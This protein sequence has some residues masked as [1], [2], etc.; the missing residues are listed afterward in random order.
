MRFH[1][2]KVTKKRLRGAGE[3]VLFGYL[4]CVITIAI[5]QRTT[6]WPTVADLASSPALI[7]QGQWWRI[8]TSG[9]VIQGPAVPQIIAIAVLGSLSIYIGGSWVFWRTAVAGHVVATLVAYGGFSAIWL[10]DHAVSTRFLTDPDY[11]VSLI[12]CAALGAFAGLSW[13]GPKPNWRKPHQPLPA[14]L[15]VIVIIV[16]TAYSDPMA[17]VQ[18]VIAFM[19]GLSIIA[20]ADQSRA[21]H[22]E[23]RTLGSQLT[24]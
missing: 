9:L 15:A 3:I 4:V 19:V 18:H 6:G 13:L 21:V 7:I 8:I 23:R 24:R 11:G 17:A 22:K 14:V 10:M 20:T 12:W 1:F 5:L 2:T 16:V